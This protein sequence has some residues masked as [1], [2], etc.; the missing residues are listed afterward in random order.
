[1]DNM[2][3]Y[4]NPVSLLKAKNPYQDIHW[5]DNFEL[6]TVLNGI[7]NLHIGF[8][9][10]ILNKGD[11]MIVNSLESHS[12]SSLEKD[13]EVLFITLNKENCLKIN[14]YFYES[15]AIV[16]YS[17][18]FL[19]LQ[20]NQEKVTNSIV[21]LLKSLPYESEKGLSRIERRIVHE[22]LTDLLNVL[23]TVYRPKITKGNE[24]VVAS[25]EKICML[26]RMIKYLYN[27]YN[28]APSLENFLSK[29]HYSLYYMS[30]VIV[31]ITGTS[32][33][34]W[35][36]YVRV[37]ESEKLLLSTDLPVSKIG[38]EVGFSSVRY[39]NANFKKWYGLTPIDY[40][41]LYKHIFDEGLQ[42]PSGDLIT[43]RSFLYDYFEHNLDY[44]DDAKKIETG[45][46]LLKVEIGNDDNSEGL[47]LF[48]FKECLIDYQDFIN[49]DRWQHLA[50]IKNEI[51]F[52]ILN[53]HIPQ[54]NSQA[55][56][57]RNEVERVKRAYVNMCNEYRKCLGE[58]ELKI[59]FNK[60]ITKPLN[61]NGKKS[62][63]FNFVNPSININDLVTPVGCKTPEFFFYSLL[64]H[65]R[66][67]E[68]ELSPWS[69]VYQDKSEIIIF[70]LHREAFS[71][72]HKHDNFTVA[73]NGIYGDYKF[74]NYRCDL[75]FLINDISVKS[76]SVLNY[77]TPEDYKSINGM[78]KPRVSFELVS[79]QGSGEIRSQL[80]GNSCQLIILEKIIT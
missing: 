12:F 25:E 60:N 42:I 66:D 13:T 70:I 46:F 7:L 52:D 39:Y 19:Q 6:I 45:E 32:F 62:G 78:H 14:P 56:E 43:A 2:R 1:M 15:I 72:D 44:V 65:F 34:D 31:E 29:E 16:D 63:T 80:L 49:I 33:R 3:Q 5:H 17:V 68:V 74:T 24:L 77:L 76:P 58:M 23:S 8:E 59:T 71:L 11:I 47:H 35:L 61:V 4:Q 26:Y 51:G 48:K 27:N 57:V 79:Y 54:V 64:G 67:K 53:I 75:D 9:K 73:L 38:R 28:K 18:G 37:E 21:A 55:T 40:R 20:E 36:T 30:H 50:W 22:R 41:R 69:I 10:F